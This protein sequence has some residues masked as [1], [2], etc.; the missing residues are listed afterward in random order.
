MT[1]SSNGNICRV[2][3]PLGGEFTGHRWI[4]LTKASDAEVW[5]F[6]WSAPGQMAE[7]T[8]EMPVI[9]DVIALI[10]TSLYCNGCNGIYMS[11][12]KSMLHCSHIKVSMAAADHLAPIWRHSI[13][14]VSCFVSYISLFFWGVEICLPRLGEAWF[15]NLPARKK[16]RNPKQ[17]ITL[18]DKDINPAATP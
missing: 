9:W 3:G 16:Y 13:G 11:R 5:C 14:V 12:N 1:T 4:P 10:M 17:L 6:L 2:A 15:I 7:R 18:R 8:I